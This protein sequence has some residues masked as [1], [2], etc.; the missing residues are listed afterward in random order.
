[1]NDLRAWDS[2]LEWILVRMAAIRGELRGMPLPVRWTVV[3]SASAGV[4]GAIV[5]LAAGL[6]YPPTAWFAVFEL[7]IPAAIAGGVVGLVAGLIVAAG[8]R[9]T[10]TDRAIGP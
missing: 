9:F 8:R 5:G 1:M 2:F 10:R 7:G 6:S 3:G 4:I